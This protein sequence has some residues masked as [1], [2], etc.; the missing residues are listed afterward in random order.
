MSA[1]ANTLANMSPLLKQTYAKKPVSS[2]EKL[3][4]KLKAPKVNNASIIPKP[5]KI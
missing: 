1:A 5:K 3:K 2:F 4:Q